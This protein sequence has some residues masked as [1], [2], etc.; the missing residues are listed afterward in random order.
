MHQS[1]MS[2]FSTL[3]GVHS[4]QY[5]FS[6]LDVKI[7]V[8][9]YDAGNCHPLSPAGTMIAAAPEGRPAAVQ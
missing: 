6:D 1:S 9:C 2:Y 3:A 5:D 8:F 7:I 4:I